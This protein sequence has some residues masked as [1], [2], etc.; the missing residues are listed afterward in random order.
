MKYLMPIPSGYTLNSDSS[1]EL[2][3]GAIEL[4]DEQYSGLTE[5]TLTIIN[6]DIVNV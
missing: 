1:T 3:E 4:T 5:G 2:P 6:G